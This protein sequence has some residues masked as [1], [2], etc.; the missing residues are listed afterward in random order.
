MTT[1]CILFLKFHWITGNERTNDSYRSVRQKQQKK[2]QQQPVPCKIRTD[3]TAHSPY[4]RS[5]SSAATSKSNWNEE[6]ADDKLS[7][8]NDSS[9]NS[10]LVK[11]NMIIYY[12]RQLFCLLIVIVTT[13][14]TYQNMWVL[15][16]SI[17]M[18]SLYSDLTQSICAISVHRDNWYRL[19][20]NRSFQLNRWLMIG[21][22]AIYSKLKPKWHCPSYHLFYFMLHGQPIANMRATRTILLRNFLTSRPILRQ[23][24]A[25]TRW[26]NADNNT[27]R[28][29]NLC[30][31]VRAGI[32]KNQFSINSENVTE[33]V[34]LIFSFR[35]WCLGP[36]WWHTI[37]MVLPFRIVD[38]GRTK[39]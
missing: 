32:C 2:Q 38:S 35:R 19:K 25:G 18:A 14:A 8:T 26:A 37:R 24:T 4:R 34:R 3:E 11:S 27:P 39:H 1:I 33:N 9:S 28:Y 12:V 21:H 16:Q 29:A 23:S 20:W 10:Q 36:F 7:A 30:N 13:Y 31:W 5:S 17:D 6:G 22:R 15:N